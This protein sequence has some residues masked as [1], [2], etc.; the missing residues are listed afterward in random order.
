MI[1]LIA[2]LPIPKA[3]RE[4]LEVASEVAEGL[5]ARLTYQVVADIGE[6]PADLN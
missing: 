3:G 6:R 5:P 4:L 2:R 1:D